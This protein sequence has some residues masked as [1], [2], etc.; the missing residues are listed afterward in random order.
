MVAVLRYR[1]HELTD[2]K[3]Q[4]IGRLL[5]EE[6]TTS[7][8]AL[9]RKLCEAWGWVQENGTL[10]DVWCRGML[11]ALHR[12]G[13]ITL[14][15]ARWSGLGRAPRRAPPPVDVPVEPL[16]ASLA[17]LGPLELRQVRRTP[18]EAVVQSLIEQHHY[19]GY[20]QPVGEHLKYLV[21]AKGRPIA[22]FCWSSAP[23]HLGPRDKYILND[24]LISAQCAEALA[25]LP[26]P[27]IT[28]RACRSRLRWLKC[29]GLGC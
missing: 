2:D 19:L 10:R 14:P 4:F 21:T 22:C 3:V 18:E 1:G 5:A 16:V 7:R 23:R 25:A 26:A 13:H 27:A 8:R 11:L 29:S 28:R 17:E 12:A 20:T 24:P 15:P 9:S 6:P